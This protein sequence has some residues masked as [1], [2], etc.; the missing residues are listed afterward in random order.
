MKQLVLAL[1]LFCILSAE[2]QD[3]LIYKNAV[4]MVVVLK[5]ISQNEI[6]YQKYE[7]PDGPV[8]VINKSDIDKIIYK[9]GM[10]EKIQPGYVP[11]TQAAATVTLQGTPYSG[12]IE[13]NDTK[14]GYR[15]MRN[16]ALGHVDAKRQPEL[17]DLAKTTRKYKNGMDGTRTG[18]IV[19]GGLAVGGAFLYGVATAFGNSGDDATLIAPPVGLAILAAGLTSVSVVFSIKLKK[20]RFAFVNLY[21][22]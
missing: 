22:E 12:K 2:A 9:N 21:N 4:K 15:S 8:Y 13:Y 14:K 7:L 17:I 3:T 16:L 20:K 6:R 1:T 19:C 18:A 10:V 5:E 11:V